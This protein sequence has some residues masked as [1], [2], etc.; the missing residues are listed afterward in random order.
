ML[1]LQRCPIRHCTVPNPPQDETLR[2]MIGV[3][4]L[5]GRHFGPSRLMFAEQDS[6][7]EHSAQFYLIMKMMRVRSN[8]P[9]E[10]DIT[11]GIILSVL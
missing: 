2:A 6:G 1:M 3:G 9:R 10:R 5:V 11:S 7:F 8:W 4:R